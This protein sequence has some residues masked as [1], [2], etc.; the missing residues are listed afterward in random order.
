MFQRIVLIFMRLSIKRVKMCSVSIRK[1][2]G[3]FI[4]QKW[5]LFFLRI[6]FIIGFSLRLIIIIN[7]ENIDIL[8]QLAYMD[9]AEYMFGVEGK[10]YQFPRELLFPFLLGFIFLF[11]PNTILTKRIFTAVLGSANIVIVFFVA[12]KYAAKFGIINNNEKFGVV[13]SLLVCFNNRLINYDGWTIRIEDN[14]LALVYNNHNASQSA[15]SIGYAL[16]SSWDTTVYFFSPTDTGFLNRNFSQVTNDG[17]IYF[18]YCDGFDFGPDYDR[19]ISLKMDG[20][21]AL[22]IHHRMLQYFRYYAFENL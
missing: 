10:S 4:C 17:N 12:K 7:T 5:I 6:L 19:V 15:F 22:Y 21:R 14:G 13:A 8:D 16:N 18:Y 9:I 2:V 3:K 20:D 1:R 11:S